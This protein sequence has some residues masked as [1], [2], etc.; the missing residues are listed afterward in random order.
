[1]PP[2]AT[3]MRGGAGT[4]PIGDRPGTTTAASAGNMAQTAAG[5]AHL[6][7]I[8]AFVLIVFLHMAAENRFRD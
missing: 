7:A 1:M 6:F 3:P 2:T 5:R 8:G 4:T